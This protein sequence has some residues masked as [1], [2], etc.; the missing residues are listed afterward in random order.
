MKKT[1]LFSAIIIFL[2][3]A[4]ETA[5][6][7]P[8]IPRKEQLTGIDFSKYTK[9]GFLITPEKYSGNYESIGLITFVFMPGATPKTNI[10]ENNY[11]WKE[12]DN[13]ITGYSWDIEKVNLQDAIDAMYKRCTEMGA[14]ALVN[15]NATEEITEYVFPKAPVKIKG[16]KIT[17]FAIKIK[18]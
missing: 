6:V 7:L 12:S 2:L 18:P 13:L 16:Y 10:I 9:D 8:K 4:C 15:F 17:G 3:S 5:S 14:N 1:I 11:S